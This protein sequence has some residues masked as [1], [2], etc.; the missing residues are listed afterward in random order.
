MASVL[1]LLG[2]Q[3]E[4]TSL[5]LLLQ[6]WI[7]VVACAVVERSHPWLLLQLLGQQRRSVVG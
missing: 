2:E 4:A 3:T 5:R 6:P 7:A 1:I